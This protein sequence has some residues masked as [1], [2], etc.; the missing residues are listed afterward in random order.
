MQN[1]YVFSAEIVKYLPKRAVIIFLYLTD[2]KPRYPPTNQT[3][4]PIPQPKL[5]FYEEI[6]P[7]PY[8]GFMHRAFALALLV[9]H[10]P[11]FASGH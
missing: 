10:D 6:R 9:V 3:F 8:I 7:Y 5:H 1:R 4:R 11:A 2:L